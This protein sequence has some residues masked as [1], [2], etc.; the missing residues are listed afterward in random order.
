MRN[1][2]EPD[3]AQAKMVLN[4]LQSSPL[5]RWSKRIAVLPFG[6]QLIPPDVKHDVSEVV[7]DA[8]LNSKRFEANYRSLEAGTPKAYVF[9]PLGLVYRQGVLYL[10]ATLWDYDDVRHFALHRMSNATLRD[11]PLTAI[12]G[13]EFERYVRE[14]KSFDYPAGKSIRLELIVEAWLARHLDESRLSEDQTIQ[15]IQGTDTFRV[16]ASVLD[17][18]QLFWWLRSLGPDVEII[19]PATM[20]RKMITQTELLSEK[21]S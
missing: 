21:Y 9:N 5:G 16:A 2:L 19:K 13:F 20:R 14:E 1:H 4:Q 7:Y 3:F 12:D 10:V 6:H 8:L 17:T 15:A 18:D 11:E